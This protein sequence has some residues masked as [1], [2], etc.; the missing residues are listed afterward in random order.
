[1]PKIDVSIENSI[2]N[3]TKLTGTDTVLTTDVGESGTLGVGIAG[4]HTVG[5]RAAGLGVGE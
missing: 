1:V 3:R 2:G 5:V 4:S